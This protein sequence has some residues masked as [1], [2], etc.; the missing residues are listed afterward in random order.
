MTYGLIII[1]IHL[2]FFFFAYIP[3]F[4]LVFY[5]MRLSVI[6]ALFLHSV[7]SLNVFMGTPLCHCLHYVTDL[8]IWGK[9]FSKLYLLTPRGVVIIYGRGGRWNSNLI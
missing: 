5:N 8:H 7:D 4:A 9:L 2:F 1:F 3:Q 6:Y